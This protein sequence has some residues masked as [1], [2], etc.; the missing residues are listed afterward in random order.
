MSEG[1]VAGVMRR[2]MLEK[3]S[4]KKYSVIEKNLSVDDLLDAD[5][6][7][8]TNSIHPVRW[9]KNF[10]EKVYGNERVKEIFECFLKNI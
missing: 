9:V 6:F 8:L 2:W 3:F 7:F 5:E 1:C 4:L 10:K